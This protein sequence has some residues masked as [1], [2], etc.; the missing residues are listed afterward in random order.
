MALNGFSYHGAFPDYGDYM[1]YVADI[2]ATGVQYGHRV[3]ICNMVLSEE[4][5]TDPIKLLHDFA[6]DK[7]GV[8]F[9]GYDVTAT[10]S[11]LPIRSDIFIR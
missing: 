10:I 6:Y 3:E 5:K 9:G 8:F 11:Y 4:W 7:V 2:W 1:Y